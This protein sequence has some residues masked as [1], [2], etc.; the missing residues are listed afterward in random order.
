MNRPGMR[1][2][3]TLRSV[4]SIKNWLSLSSSFASLNRITEG[5]DDA[6]TDVGA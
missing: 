4:V 6:A 2:A 3:A 1:G 5:I